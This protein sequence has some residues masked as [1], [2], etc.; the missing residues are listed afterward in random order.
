MDDLGLSPH[1]HQDSIFLPIFQ[2]FFSPNLMEK[3]SQDNLGIN[4]LV[5]QE[6]KGG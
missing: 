5:E 1:L 4:P 3:G 2:G 6:H